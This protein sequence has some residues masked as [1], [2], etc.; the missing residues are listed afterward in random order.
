MNQSERLFRPSLLP[1]FLESEVVDAGRRGRELVEMGLGLTTREGKFALL[2]ALVTSSVYRSLIETPEKRAGLPSSLLTKIGGPADNPHF[3]LDLV[4]NLAVEQLT[5]AHRDL[6]QAGVHLY[7][8]ESDSFRPI[9]PSLKD[10][11]RA[12]RLVAI[13]GLDESKGVARHQYHQAFG[14]LVADTN[15]HLLSGAVASYVDDRILVMENGQAVRFRFDPQT[16]LLRTESA[17]VPT[18][19]KERLRYAMLPQRSGLV[20]G[21]DFVHNH[22][23]TVATFGGWA[24]LELAFDN[25]SLDLVI[26]PRG[27]KAHEACYWGANARAAGLS[28]TDLTGETLDF[29]EKF[30][31]LVDGQKPRIPIVIAKPKALQTVLP[32]LAELEARRQAFASLKS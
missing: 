7:T 21:T 31:L 6:L 22:T 18:K 32:E 10:Y 14:L 24:V 5:V 19:P 20:D 2:S 28:V 27:Q 26:D 1:E 17:R 30:K 8:E 3:A 9:I 16:W 13:D 4:G 29:D 23:L 11:P 12:K 15:R 25:G